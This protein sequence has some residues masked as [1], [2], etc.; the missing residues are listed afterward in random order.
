MR[1]ALLAAKTM[2]SKA[3][4][5]WVQTNRCFANGSP[6]NARVAET[7]IGRGLE[8]IVNHWLRRWREQSIGLTSEKQANI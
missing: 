5:L 6:R 4:K 7:A 8:A 1:L 2:F 3:G